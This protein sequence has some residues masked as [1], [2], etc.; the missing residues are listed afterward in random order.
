MRF[1]DLR[2]VSEMDKKAE[3]YEKA[4]L[5]AEQLLESRKRAKSW[6]QYY[7]RGL[8]AKPIDLLDSDAGLAAVLT[9]IGRLEHGVVTSIAASATLTLTCAM[10]PCWR[11]NYNLQTLNRS[12]QLSRLYIRPSCCDFT[13]QKWLGRRSNAFLQ[14]HTSADNRSHIRTIPAT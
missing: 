8:D 11:A 13:Y 9:I 10:T 14:L 7:V 4:L 5:A 1:L 2:Y 12:L 3:R 6:L